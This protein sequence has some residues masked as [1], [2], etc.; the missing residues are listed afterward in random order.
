MA[1]VA[2]VVAL[3]AAAHARVYSSFVPDDAWISLHYARRLLEGHGLTWTSGEH[4]EG[5]SNQLFVLLCAGG[6]AL[7]LDLLV[8][9][10][11]V[12]GLSAFAMALA[13]GWA[14]RP[15]DRG[16][17]RLAA[18][19]AMILLVTSGPVA[20]WAMGGLEATLLGALVVWAAV[21]TF[22][23]EGESHPHRA[24]LLLALA[25]WTR[26][27]GYLFAGLFATALLASTRSN[28]RVRLSRG[29]ALVLLP[30]VALLAQLGFRL[31][32]YGAFVPNTAL[33]KVS[34]SAFT[35]RGGIEYLG[36]GA[37]T[38]LPV[39]LAALAGGIIAGGSP[40]VRFLGMVSLGWLGY[41]V[42]IG[43]DWMPAHRH[44]VPVLPLLVLVTAILFERSWRIPDVARRIAIGLG[45]VTALG[46]HLAL[47][48]VSPANLLARDGSGWVWKCAELATAMG[49][50]LA[51]ENPLLAADAAGCW[52]YF[53]RFRTI[54]MLGLADRH[55]AVH[56]HDPTIHSVPG[57]ALGD[58][59]YVLERQ[60]DLISF[61][62]LGTQFPLFRSGLE[63]IAG[64]RLAARY[65]PVMVAAGGIS[66]WLWVRKEG[67]A[68]GVRAEP[69]Q[70]VIP[71][72]QLASTGGVARSGAGGDLLTVGPGPLV[73]DGLPLGPGL[74]R[75]VIDGAVG[76]E[77]RI[78][79]SATSGLAEA[80]VSGMTV[81]LPEPTEVKLSLLAPAGK[82]LSVRQVRIERH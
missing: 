37:R 57:H 30:T 69:G 58:G 18:V 44:F 68:L 17:T 3:V 10:R 71:A 1:A 19:L 70:M 52:P 45:T 79:L 26:A 40:M 66:A 36:D 14:F 24:G 47:Q 20:A 32:Y 28:L 75:V 49:K 13:V 31:I 78:E 38:L 77:P 67:G 39:V 50:S 62:G 82:V 41:L 59:S 23:P 2:T 5:Y 15:W 25:T 29:G 73:I 72:L 63:M 51:K 12:G 64:G 65:R 42:V 54:D 48:Q 11:V 46:F 9:A 34:I 43:G 74:F 4:V 60:P 8:A 55:I 22:G 61:G 80:G 6:G 35:L 53:G 56:G 76:A 16:S 33:A 21:L 81:A 7:G 27:D